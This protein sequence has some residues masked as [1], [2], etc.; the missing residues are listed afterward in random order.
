MFDS[1]LPSDTVPR[2]SES[3]NHGCLGPKDYNVSGFCHL[4]P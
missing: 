1:G 4:K 2:E 3:Q